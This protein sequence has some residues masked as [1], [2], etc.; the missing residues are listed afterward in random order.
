MSQFFPDDDLESI[1][2]ENIL[3]D[4]DFMPKLPEEY[5][6]QLERE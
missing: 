4:E 3:P 5:R 2:D 1:Q 6:K